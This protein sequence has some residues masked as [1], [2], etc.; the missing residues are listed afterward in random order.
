MRVLLWEVVVVYQHI[1]T[2]EFHIVKMALTV[3]QIPN[4]KATLLT[5][6]LWPPYFGLF[7]TGTAIMWPDFCVLL[8][9]C[10]YNHIGWLM[11]C[12]Y[13]GLVHAWLQFNQFMYFS[14]CTLSIILFVVFTGLYVVETCFVPCCMMQD[15]FNIEK[16]IMFMSYFY[17]IKYSEVKTYIYYYI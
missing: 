3:F 2:R 11:L 17:Q 9:T 4:L 16:K 1:Y 8:V 10:T 15:C 6:L 5:L 12:N 13:A 14:V 7:H